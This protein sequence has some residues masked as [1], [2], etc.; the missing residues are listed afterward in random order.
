MQ[1]IINTFIFIGLAFTS[2]AQTHNEMKIKFQRRTN[3]EK[4]YDDPRMKRMINNSNKIRLESFM[5]NVSKESS[6]FIPVESETQDRMS[7]MTSKNSYYQDLSQDEQLIIFSLFGN[8]VY[9]KDSLP[10]RP[11]KITENTRKIAGYECRKAIYQKNDSTRIYAWYSSAFIPSVG[12]EG[13]CGLPGTILGV[14]TEDGGIIYFAEEIEFVKPENTL[15]KYKLGKSKTKTLAELK[16]DIEK[17]FGNQPWGKR[18]FDD[19][20]RWL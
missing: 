1:K 10:K 7:W 8:K 9:V 16:A 14:A 17:K 13:F 6:S 18:M 15:L 2:T 12:P 20:F 5:L 19:L 3:L 11:W 4:R